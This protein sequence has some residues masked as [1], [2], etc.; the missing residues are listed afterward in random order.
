MLSFGSSINEFVRRYW[1]VLARCRVW[2]QNLNLETLAC[3]EPMSHG[4]SLEVKI[5]SL[6]DK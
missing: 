5:G 1:S 4:K 6:G 2:V 3:V